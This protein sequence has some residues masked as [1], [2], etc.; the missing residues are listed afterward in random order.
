MRIM[1]GATHTRIDG[2]APEQEAYKVWINDKQY[3]NVIAVDTEQGFAL[4]QLYDRDGDPIPNKFGGGQLAILYGKVE[5]RK[6][7]E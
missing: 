7:N 3:D 6:P 4:V 2:F 1:A 5:L